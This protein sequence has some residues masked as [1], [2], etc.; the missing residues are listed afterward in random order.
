MGFYALQ[1]VSVQAFLANSKED[2]IVALLKQVK[3]ANAMAKA[4]VIVLDNY[5]SHWAAKVTKTAQE[6]GI[7]LIHWPPYSPDLNPIEYIWKSIKRIL[8]REFVAT[9]DEMKSKIAAGWKKLSGSLGFAKHW[10]AE[11]LETESYYNNLCV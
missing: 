9:L 6:L 11:F 10:I 5:K 4:I 8:S 2:A 3:A 1:G 7:Y